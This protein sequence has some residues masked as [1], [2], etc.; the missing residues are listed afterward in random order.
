MQHGV[1]PPHAYPF[2]QVPFLLTGRSAPAAAVFGFAVCFGASFGDAG[3]VGGRGRTLTTGPAGCR[4]GDGD[5][6]R[7]GG[8]DGA[9]G[10]GGG[11]VGSFESPVGAGTTSVMVM[12]TGERSS[13]GGGGGG[14][15]AATM[16]EEQRPKS[17]LHPVPH[18]GSVVPLRFSQ[19]RHLPHLRDGE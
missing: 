18:H 3:G 12:V 13:T 6:R 11:A 2:P 15:D 16:L 19:H 7:G 17:G 1:A 5:D 8:G 4:P 10:G 9:G 14:G